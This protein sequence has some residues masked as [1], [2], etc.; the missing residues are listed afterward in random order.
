MIMAIISKASHHAK[1]IGMAMTLCVLA[2]S[3]NTASETLR[4]QTPSASPADEATGWTI[5]YGFSGGIAGIYK[6]LAMHADGTGWVAG[7]PGQKIELKLT[8]E[9]MARIRALVEALPPPAPAKPGSLKHEIYDDIHSTFT[10]SRAGETRSI[11]QEGKELAGVL[12]AILEDELK[13]SSEEAWVKA[14]PFRL[15]RVWKVEEEV[16][17]GQ[18]MWHGELWIGTWTRINNSNVFDAVWRNNKSN[19]ELRDTVVLDSAERGKIAMHRKSSNVKY[20]GWYSPERQDYFTGHVLP[21]DDW[22]WRVN[23]SY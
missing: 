8:A 18:G 14:G 1:C 9:Q 7:R 11:G 17:D 21:H 10:L 22:T 23:I 5:E 12:D 15:G 4:P 6:Y 3:H 19:L 16:R 13:R 20:D 2:L